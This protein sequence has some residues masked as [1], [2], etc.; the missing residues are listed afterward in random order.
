MVSSFLSPPNPQ[1]DLRQLLEDLYQGRSLVD[2]SAGQTIPLNSRDV[3]VVYRGV[4][5]LS[6]LHPNGEESLL[7]FATPSMVFGLPLT[8]IACYQATALSDVGLMRFNVG[9]I[10]RSPALCSSLWHQLGRR[11]RQTESILALVGHRRIK[12]RLQQL[13]LHLKTEMGYPTEEG[14][15]L[16]VKLTHQNIANT[17]GTTRV[18]VTR[19]IKELRE[20]GWL[21]IDI[22]RYITICEKT[23]DTY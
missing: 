14:V 8:T 21:T 6:V 9:E 4:V 19:L 1:T 11:L 15:R 12:D 7:G 10:E 18:T 16:S 5:S 2:F 17:I 13:L 20:E 3:W 22:Q 23:R